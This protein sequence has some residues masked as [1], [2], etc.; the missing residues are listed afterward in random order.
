MVDFLVHDPERISR[1]D[2]F[3]PTP[4]SISLDPRQDSQEMCRREAYSMQYR[5]MINTT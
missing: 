2:L 4:H 3:G 5:Q 1:P